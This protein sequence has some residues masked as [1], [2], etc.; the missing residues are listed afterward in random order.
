MAAAAGMQLL[1]TLALAS[2][3]LGSGITQAQ[4]VGDVRVK[5]QADVTAATISSNQLLNGAVFYFSSARM[6]Q[7]AAGAKVTLAVT[8]GPG[9]LSAMPLPQQ[10]WRPAVLRNSPVQLVADQDGAFSLFAH[11]LEAGVSTITATVAYGG[12]TR[13]V[14]GGSAVL[15]WLDPAATFLCALDV[16][17]AGQYVSTVS[18]VFVYRCSMRGAGMC[19]H[20]AWDAG[21]LEHCC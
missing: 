10:V 16:D 12:T 8:E 5:W 3:L 20:A 19:C 11:S 4:T 18:G 9:Q 21:R 15:S 14:A 6:W 7:P 13:V 17:P 1:C 2:L